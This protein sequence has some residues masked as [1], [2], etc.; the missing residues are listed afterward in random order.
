MNSKPKI[1]LI[2]L[3]AQF[4]RSW[5]QTPNLQELR[6]HFDV[7]LAA[8]ANVIPLLNELG[9]DSVGV[10]IP[11]TNFALRFSAAFAR[12]STRA[13][14]KTYLFN[15]R[16][17]FLGHQTLTRQNQEL[18]ISQCLRILKV[19][20]R[21]LAQVSTNVLALF[22]LLLPIQANRLLA[23]LFVGLGSSTRDARNLQ[24]SLR[25]YSVVI[26]ATNASEYE[27]P[28]LLKGVKRSGALSVVAPDN[29]DN[30]STKAAFILKPDKLLAMGPSAVEPA[31]ERHSLRKEQFWVTGLPK[32]Q[33][34]H[35]ITQAGR[36]RKGPALMIGYLG[37][38]QSQREK[39]F[40]NQVAKLVLDEL[41]L[42]AKIQFRTHPF[43]ITMPV[44]E[45]ELD[46]RILEHSHSRVEREKF[47]NYPSLDPESGYYDELLK[48]DFVISGPTTLALE[49][50]ILGIPTIID[51]RIQPDLFS[52]PMNSLA[53][54]PHFRDLF[55]VPNL[56]IFYSTEE[57]L[58]LINQ[59]IEDRE[60]YRPPEI[61]NLVEKRSFTGLLASHLSSELR[62][63]PKRFF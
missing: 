10:K 14:R 13:T 8:K 9:Y 20:L 56:Q 19:Y 60:S 37:Y 48:F 57:G 29:W 55:E 63:P 51:M 43:R 12:S 25:P 7:E 23:Q 34:L 45:P 54:Y 61:E 11:E 4:A 44:H 24:L 31:M 22:P 53:A 27:L 15:L 6:S 39:E 58:G 47:G 36:R 35:S 38:S 50:L 33:F 1:L 28:A 40:L 2:L 5:I 21:G 42:D 30:L 59:W 46:T 41:S 26:I 49:T 52:S 62:L 18:L 32:F 3:N 16:R 17:H